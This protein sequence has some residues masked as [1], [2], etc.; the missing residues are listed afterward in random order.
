MFLAQEYRSDE[1]FSLATSFII[2]SGL[3]GKNTVSIRSLNYPDYYLRIRNKFTVVLEQIDH[4][5]LDF[6]SDSS[7]FVKKGLADPNLISFELSSSPDVFLRQYDDQVI[8]GKND[9]TY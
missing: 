3:D 9:N 4:S 5:D 8:A 2:D 7:F 6:R 1:E